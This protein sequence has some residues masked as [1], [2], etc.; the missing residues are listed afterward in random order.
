V[1]ASPL[2]GLAAVLV[3]AWLLSLNRKAIEIRPVVFGIALQLLLTLTVLRA[4]A[5][6]F[7]GMGLL[8]LWIA[9]F[10]VRGAPA[11]GTP[12]KR[13]VLALLALTALGVVVFL[14]PPALCSWL[15]GGAALAL[16]ADRR[17]RIPV[18]IRSSVAAAIPVLGTAWLAQRKIFGLELLESIGTRVAGFLDLADYGSRFL[19]GNLADS[20]YYYPETSAWP[21]FGFL[22]AFKLLPVIVFFAAVVSILYSLGVM[23]ATIEALSRFLRWSAGTSGAETLCASANIF[24]GQTEAPLLIR[25]YLADATKSELMSVMVAG[26]ATIA[27]G[28]L[29][30]YIAL[31]IPAAHLIAASVLS[32]PAAL[33]IA[34]IVLPETGNPQTRGDVGL[35]RVDV[36]RNIIEAATDGI[37]DGLRLAVNVGA[38]LIGFIS[39]MAVLDSLLNVADA[40]I[41][42]SLLAGSFVEYR[43]VGF[44]PVSGEYEGIFPG[45]LRTV[46]GAVLRPI[47]WLLGVPWAEAGAIGNLLGIKL[48][49][50]EFVA[51]GTL[52]A[53]ID[54]G[55]LSTRSI[56]IAAYA[57]CGFANVSSIGMQIG[58]LSALAPGRRADFARFGLRAMLAGALAS[59]MTAAIAGLQL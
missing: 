14:L 43:A 46:F 4:D 53:H 12:L 17:G 31:G 50:N 22:F 51:Y 13:T 27:G 36:G 38:M 39:L 54:D 44:S 16:L 48:S 21:G 58:G 49:L 47:A 15:L 26:F 57:L 19:F 29:A 34:K 35:P 7:V 52:A 18:S 1:N 9:A 20:A 59:W 56:A 11:D 2:L 45:S 28:A 6:S 37:R 24:I 10:V 40:W 41:D 5:W 23:Q 55:S 25:P 32:A 33:V 3:A 30:G 8:S 42:G